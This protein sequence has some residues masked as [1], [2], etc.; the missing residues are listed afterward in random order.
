MDAPDTP[1]PGPPGGATERPPATREY[2][3]G[4]LAREAGI[5]VRTVRY[6]QELKLL[7]PP[8]RAGRV[9]W[10]SEAHLARLR[11]IG[12]LLRRGHTLGGAGELLAAWE[13]GYDLGTL[14]GI[15][16][17]MT[18]SWSAEAPVPV[19]VAGISAQL[20]DQLT[21]DVLAE[22]A[23]L[24][25]VE[26]DGDQVRV[27]RRLLETTTIL[28]REGI[29]LPAILAAGRELQAGLDSMASLLVELVISNIPGGRGGPPGPDE[30]GRLADTIERLRP[31]A[32]TVIDAEFARAMDRR[33][34]VAYRDFIRRLGLSSESCQ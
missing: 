5:T 28:V 34:Q 16:Q 2:R 21:P 31:V 19:S 33:A 26:L 17:A 12:D 11:I 4:E 30:I 10:Y 29:P 15:E 13:R 6:Y 23:R 8:R 20:H 22:A 24:G 25:Y 27:S 18:A 14:L 32:R 9:G 3:V 1:E 7:P